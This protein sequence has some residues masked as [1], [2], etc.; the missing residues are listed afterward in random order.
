MPRTPLAERPPRTPPP[1]TGIMPLRPGQPGAAPPSAPPATAPIPPTAP[2]PPP[3][4][5]PGTSRA[6]RGPRGAASGAGRRGPAG[7][8]GRRRVRDRDPRVGRRVVRDPGGAAVARRVVGVVGWVV[9][10]GRPWFGSHRG[11]VGGRRSGCPSG[12]GCCRTAP[13]EAAGAAS[14]RG[15]SRRPRPESCGCRVSASIASWA[16]V[17][18]SPY[19]FQNWLFLVFQSRWAPA[20]VRSG[21]CCGGWS[22]ACFAKPSLAFCAWR[23]AC[24]ASREGRRLRRASRPRGRP[25]S[26]RSG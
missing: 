3:T 13:A 9:R 16:W 5:P 21:G 25:S 18:L 7:P 1:P 8:R 14:R 22:P 6:V 19:W 23:T 17:S 26:W 2:T 10:V 12:T 20:S 11:H 15:S 24:A 4:P